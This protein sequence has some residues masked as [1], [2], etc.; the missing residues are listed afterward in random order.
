MS[1][2]YFRPAAATVAAAALAATV[3]GCTGAVGPTSDSAPIPGIT[4]ELINAA[5]EEGGVTLAAGGHTRTQLDQLKESFES[6]FG[7][8][9]N[10]TRAD[11]GSTVN[12]VN[13][14]LA[15]GKLNVDV[16]SL[17][18]AKSMQ[19]WADEGI[20]A[21]VAIE[22][23]ADIDPELDSA[24][25]PQIPFA[26]VP[27]GIMYNSSNTD[28]A[29]LPASWEQL[30]DS[31]FVTVTADPRAS[32]SALTF[33]TVMSEELGQDWLAKF[34]ASRPIVTE[35]TLGLNQLVLT[36]EA[37]LGMP[38]LESTVLTSAAEGEPLAI[39]YPD[40]QI[41]TAVLTIAAMAQAPHPNAAEL[42]VRYQLSEEFQTILGEA[43]TRG[44]LEGLP[45]PE[46]AAELDPSRLTTVSV[47]ELNESGD[48][49]RDDFATQVSS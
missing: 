19:G 42:L 38:A 29:A 20:L 9:V 18:D 16:V 25:S 14:E 15:S 11:S 41:P 10:F 48:V 37:D 40:G 1:H 49:V 30:V 33:Y 45:T 13:S 27:M 32:G 34:G 24:D 43:G 31:G 8:A 35:S 4:E 17:A 5:R 21:P 26:V 47:A 22:N 3:V 28:A 39:A 44:S 12:S 23:Q 7:V 2:N 36:G 6:R 46:G